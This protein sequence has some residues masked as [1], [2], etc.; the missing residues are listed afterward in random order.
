MGSLDLL[1]NN[2]N[3]NDAANDKD[4]ND[5]NND[6]DDDND[7]NDIPFCT[8]DVDDG[9]E[10]S[11]MLFNYPSVKDTTA[12][13]LAEDPPAMTT[14]VTTTSGGTMAL[15]MTPLEFKALVASTPPSNP[16]VSPPLP[17][18]TATLKAHDRRWATIL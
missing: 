15:A 1:C 12:P 17:E 8:N 5:G 16:D 4:N 7:N 11:P 14:N 2:D 18:V 10:F 13:V 3:D 6:K 9:E